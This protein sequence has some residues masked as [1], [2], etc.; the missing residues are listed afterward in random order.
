MSEEITRAFVE[1]YAANFMILSQQKGSR[2]EA[3]VDVDHDIVGASKTVERIGAKNAQK[4]DTRHADTR[5]SDTPHTRRWLDLEDWADADLIDELD[6]VR[7]LADPTSPYVMALVMSL[8]RAKDDVIIE[9]LTGTARASTES[10]GNIVLPSTQK[11]AAAATGLTVDKLIAAKQILDENEVDEEEERYIATTSE[12]IS[13][14]LTDPEVTSS[15]F[16]TV[17]ALLEGKIDTYMGL[18]FIRSERLNKVS[19]SRF[20]PVWAKT[21]LR[22]GIGRDIVNTID[23]LPQKNNSTQV[24][25]SMSLGAVRTEEARVV[26]IACIE[27]A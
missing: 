26:E 20:C 5:Y 3:A 13:N 19:T 24:Y 22:L 10:G 27:T 17:K 6:K 8:N 18:K 14:L 9:A 12:Q 21:G 1:Q 4:I 11:I 2:F 25:A 23:R 7:M 15:D 16:V